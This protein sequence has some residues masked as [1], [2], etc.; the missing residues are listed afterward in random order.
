MIKIIVIL[1]S[2][3]KNGNN[4]NKLE[5]SSVKVSITYKWNFVYLLHHAWFWF[6]LS[7]MDSKHLICK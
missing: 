1:I 2:T 7:R 6:D 4:L 5:N 3:L